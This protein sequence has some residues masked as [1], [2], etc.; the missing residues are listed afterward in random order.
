MEQSKRRCHKGIISVF[1]AIFGCSTIIDSNFEVIKDDGKVHQDNEDAAIK[2]SG[3]SDRK[4]T[5]KG[6]D[7]AAG[8]NSGNDENSDSSY[9]DGKDLGD[10][11]EFP[12][13]IEED[14][15]CGR[16][17]PP[18][19]MKLL[20]DDFDSYSLDSYI[21]ENNWTALYTASSSKDQWIVTDLQ[22]VSAPHSLHVYG[23]H[24]GCWSGNITRPISGEK[25]L[26]LANIRAA[27][28]AGGGCHDLDV[29]VG[30]SNQS[31][32]S[33]G[34]D[35]AVCDIRSGGGTDG[36]PTGLVCYTHNISDHIVVI[37][38]YQDA[39]NQWFEIAIDVD[40]SREEAFFWVDEVCIGS[41]SLDTTI[42]IE[43]ITIV[44]GDG[45]GWVDDVVVYDSSV[46]ECIADSYR[47][48]GRNGD[49][50]SYDS[51]DNQ[52]EM[53]ENCPDQHAE[54]INLSTKTAE[55]R[56][57][58][59]WEGDDCNTCPDDWD[60]TKD[61]SECIG[62]CSYFFDDFEGGTIHW[63]LSGADWD[64]TDTDPFSGSYSLTDSP[65]GDY[66]PNSDVSAMTS[67]SVDLSSSIEPVVSFWHRMTLGGSS[68]VI[69][70]EVS[71][72][73]G[74]NWIEVWSDTGIG[75]ISTWTFQ[76]IDVASYKSDQ[77]KIRFRLTSSSD[78]GTDDGW[79]IDDVRIGEIGAIR[80]SFPFT[81]DFES[82]LTDWAATG[83][84]TTSYSLSTSHS[85]S[86]SPLIPYIPSIDAVAMTVYPI[87][88]SSSSNPVANFWYTLDRNET[89]AERDIVV[90]EISDDGGTNWVEVWENTGTESISTWTF[91][92]VDL[93][94]YKTSK[95]KLRFRF[96]TDSG[97]EV[98]DGWFIDDVE[99]T[100]L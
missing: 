62:E 53:V 57:L 100:E 68:D 19:R 41:L 73:G 89:V 11:D 84:L 10:T 72:D 61:C 83:N 70:V 40:Y 99:I 79:Y 95:V 2:S 45:A 28:E 66:T 77:F 21:G 43:D 91:Q 34:T 5:S 39:I 50:Y 65:D 55:C 23:S 90:V 25:L 8:G 42:P 7:A 18:K 71:E 54:C 56:C 20:E 87:D 37:E 1:I 97:D 22:S 26:M 12:D 13:D 49:I 32:G 24:S 96:I 85:L 92:Q 58:Y 29:R 93:S 74:S 17:I 59:Q 38:D 33:W 76:Q 94:D 67:K 36:L 9:S 46:N 60:S 44:S 69:R 52:G 30:F 6:F 81:D 35:V 86:V 80:L 64:L 15:D 31:V 4:T 75:S 48:C 3:A 88:L 63:L 51:C 47:Q 98:G 82:G 78:G 14:G 16:Q 27:G